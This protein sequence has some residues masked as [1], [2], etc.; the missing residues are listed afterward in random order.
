ME[1]LKVTFT[2]HVSDEEIAA[3]RE[4]FKKHVVRYGRSRFPIQ[5]PGTGPNGRRLCSGCHQEVPKHRRSWCSDKCYERYVPQCVNLQVAN[6]DKGICQG[7]GGV[8]KELAERAKSEQPKFDYWAAR[9]KYP[10]LPTW[11]T[12]EWEEHKRACTIWRQS[13]VIEEYDHIIPFS[14]GG[15]TII[16]NMR[17]LCSPCHRLVTRAFHQRRAQE[18]KFRK[19]A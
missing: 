18:R 11:K 3:L 12:P 5:P 10:D 15:L 8:I 13:Q 16:E 1:T 7:C 4:E 2:L 19:A 9:D 14:E 17:T 6:R